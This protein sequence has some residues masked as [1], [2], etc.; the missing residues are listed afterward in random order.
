MQLKFTVYTY[1]YGSILFFEKDWR[2]VIYPHCAGFC[3]RFL[4]HYRGHLSAH[5]PVSPLFYFYMLSVSLSL[6]LSFLRCILSLSLEF[7]ARLSWNRIRRRRRFLQLCFRGPLIWG[8][9][10]L[11]SL[12]SAGF[13]GNEVT[14]HSDRERVEMMFIALSWFSLSSLSLPFRHKSLVFYALIA[15]GVEMWVSA[16]SFGS[17][18]FFLEIQTGKESWISLLMEIKLEVEEV[19]CS[20]AGKSLK[21][22]C[23]FI[24]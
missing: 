8:P 10:G 6:S 2:A 23:Q 11:P 1:V 13:M 20:H 15:L 3:G 5:P 19:M 9:L 21:P 12:S 4:P 16:G 24:L 7:R 14:A 17:L 22:S 18:S